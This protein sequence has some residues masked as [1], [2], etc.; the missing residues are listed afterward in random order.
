MDLLL[1]L[2]KSKLSLLIA[3]GTLSKIDFSLLPDVIFHG[4]N[5]PLSDQL[6]N[7]GIIMDKELC[8]RPQITQLSRRMYTLYFSLRKL[9][10]IPT[11][12]KS[13]LAQSILLP[14]IDNADACYL[15]ITQEQLVK[16]ER[17]QNVYI[18][19]VRSLH[20]IR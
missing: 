3:Q 14:F 6:M 13:A 5:I 20:R 17:L 18:R 11:A 4:T 1:T 12:T 15:N 10:K 8:W 2:V 7:L 19:L 16:L 9:K